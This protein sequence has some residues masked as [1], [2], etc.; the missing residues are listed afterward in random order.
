VEGPHAVAGAEPEQDDGGAL[1]VAGAEPEQDDVDGSVISEQSHFVGDHDEDYRD[2]G[3]GGDGVGEQLYMKQPA[4]ESLSKLGLE[5]FEAI[6]VK[7]LEMALPDEGEEGPINQR[8][9]QAVYNLPGCLKNAEYRAGGKSSER[10]KTLANVLK[11]LL[12]SSTL[13]HDIEELTNTMN[14]RLA[15]IANRRHQ[16]GLEKTWDKIQQK[17][18]DMARS[19]NLTAAMSL[20]LDWED[21]LRGQPIARSPAMVAE[22]LAP[23]LPRADLEFDEVRPFGDRCDDLR[24][25][26]PDTEAPKAFQLSEEQVLLSM[27]S[28]SRGRAAGQS[29]WTNSLLKSIGLHDHR[30]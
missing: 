22:L 7:L 10:K 11:R 1:E 13:L 21:G 16:V 17:S 18:T 26:E 28:L 4:M 20:I 2:M 14:V 25:Q 24:D 27:M 8:A 9:L 23:M 30:N 5:Q 3:H 29:G 15:S 12:R 6:L 19:G